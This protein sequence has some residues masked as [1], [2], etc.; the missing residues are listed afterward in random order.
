MRGTEG[1]VARA[2]WTGGLAFLLTIVTGGIWTALLLVNLAT[3]PV[4]PWSAAVMALVLWSIWSYLGGK[5]RPDRTRNARR[6]YLRANFVPRRVFTWALIAGTLSVISLAGLWIV[7]FR[8]VRIPGNALPDFSR[9]P[10]ITVVT[11]LF[12]SALVSSVA[13]EAGFRGY[14]QVA[15]QSRFDGPGAVL[16]A[17]LLI[18]PAHG[19]TQGFLWPTMLFYFLVDTMLGTTAL[20]TKSILPGLVVHTFGLLMFFGVVWPEDR[21]RQL[22]WEGGTDT[23]FWIH[24]AQAVVFATL[25]IMAFINLARLAEPKR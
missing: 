7:L 19:L 5:W 24:A 4:V 16:I 10:T 9:Y 23:W 1:W 3:S 13:E 14:C 22:L 6:H 20:L 17:A 25:A 11:I 15:L 21:H 2:A 18:A 8:L 12:T